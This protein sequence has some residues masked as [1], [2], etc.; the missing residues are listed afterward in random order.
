MGCWGIT[1]LESDT[2]LDVLGFIRDN[3]PGD[4]KLE[5]GKI[6][7]AMQK[8]GR[9]VPDV[10]A[11]CSHT[12][13]MALAEILVKFLDQ[14]IGGLDYTEEWAANDRKFSSIASFTATKESIRWLRDYVSDTLEH[15]KEKAEFS[16]KHG[17]DEGDQWGGWFAEKDWNDW[18]NHMQ[19]LVNR[20]DALCALPDDPIELIPQ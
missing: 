8:D 12:G 20:I 16:A 4:G 6:I 7:E 3:L 15:A 1:A 19:T 17:A 5:L 11:G 2:G 14:D 18:K 9:Y 10:T 13:P